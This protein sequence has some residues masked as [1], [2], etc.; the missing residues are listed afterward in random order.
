M[1]DT[2]RRR[3]IVTGGSSGIGAEVVRALAQSGLDVWLTYLSDEAEAERVVRECRNA[4]VDAHAS[5]LDLAQSD[6]PSTFVAEVHARWD[7]I[8]VLVNN[9][10]ICPYTPYDE[11]TPAEWDEV[12]NVNLRGAFLLTRAVI[13]LLRNA[14]GDRAIVNVSSL[15][16]E[17]GGF[18]AGVHYAA[19]KA[20]M[21]SLTRSFSRLLAA[22]HIRVN[23]VAPGPVMTRITDGL[24][25][26]ASAHVMDAVPLGRFA[27]ADEVAATI[28]FVASP[29]ASF[30]TGATFDING[31]LRN[32]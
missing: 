30:T 22:E 23:A 9:A 17:T 27:T 13:P 6:A 14:D 7:R 26:D 28:A 15:A 16:G 11:I 20:A 21:F 8:H 19:S 32:A 4:G 3:A 5:R 25:N 1:T 2:S 12:L 10:G 18:H 24:G 31:G 29:S